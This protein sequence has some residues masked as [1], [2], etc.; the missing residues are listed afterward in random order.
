MRDGPSKIIIPGCRDH[1]LPGNSRRKLKLP[2]DGLCDLIHLHTN[3]VR[4][5]STSTMHRDPFVKLSTMHCRVCTIS[6]RGAAFGCSPHAPKRCE[7]SAAIKYPKCDRISKRQRCA[8]HST[9][10]IA[11]LGKEGKGKIT[12]RAPT[13]TCKPCLLRSTSASHQ[14]RSCVLVQHKSLRTSNN[15]RS[16]MSKP[17]A[18]ASA[19]LG[20]HPSR[21]L[22]QHT[23]RGR[24][25]S[26]LR[27]TSGRR[28]SAG[29]MSTPRRS[30]MSS[31]HITPFLVGPMAVERGALKGRGTAHEECRTPEQMDADVA[32][33]LLSKRSKL[34]VVKYNKGL[35]GG[36]IY[37]T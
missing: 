35:L 30:K 12:L 28:I 17:K 27:T 16:A 18:A 7:I 2:H 5:P 11:G 31:R 13:Q 15:T 21:G 3:G 37:L 1:D 6:F 8:G 33:L 19:L 26:S 20:A 4:C 34:E 24:G 32:R 9:I 25:R 10:A 14:V 36:M 22:F 29:H 23:E